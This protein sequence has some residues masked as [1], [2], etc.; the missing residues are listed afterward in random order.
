MNS[1]RSFSA[2]AVIVASIASNSALA[3]QVRAPEDTT[4]VAGNPAVVAKNDQPVVAIPQVLVTARKF[5][6][7]LQDAPVA[8]SAFTAANLENRGMDNLSE[9]GRATPSLTFTTGAVAS[10]TSS[11]TTVFMRGLGQSDY[12]M[13]VEPAVGIY[14]DGVYIARSVGSA[15]DFVDVESIEVLRGPQGTLF[16]RNTIGGVINVNSKRPEKEF[17]GDIKV[18]TGSFD[19]RVLQGSLNVPVSD[20][21]RTK[22]SL[23][24]NEREGNVR[25]IPTGIDLGNTNVVAG[26]FQAEIEPSADFRA[27]LSADMTKRRENPT[28]STAIAMSGT[29]FTPSGASLPATSNNP[30]TVFNRSLGGVCATKP[31][32]SSNCYGAA[33]LTNDP[34]LDNGTN[35][36][37]TH[38][39]TSGIS[40]VLEGRLGSATLKSI[41]GYRKLEAH[42]GRESDHTPLAFGQLHF[43]DNQDQLSQELQLNGSAFDNRFRYVLGGYGFKENSFEHFLN[44][45]GGTSTSDAAIHM[46]NENFAVFGEGTYDLLPRLHLTLGG[47][48]TDESKWFQ[49]DQVVIDAPP[50]NKALI[51]RLLVSDNSEQKVTFNQFTPRIILAADVVEGVMAYGTYSKGFKSGGFNGRYSNPVP[52]PIPFKP[53]FVTLYEA[54]LKFARADRKLR[55]N[56]AAFR[57]DYKDI[58]VNFKPDQTITVLGNAAAGQINGLEAELTWIPL[59]GLQFEGGLS[60]LDARYTEIG[61]GVPTGPGGI[62]LYTPFPQTPKWQANLSASYDFRLAN[63]SSVKPRI[64]VNYRDKASLDSVDSPIIRQPAYTLV[65]ANLT[66]VPAGGNWKLS[67]GVTN[68]TDK[69]YFTAG[70]FTAGGGI[71]DVIYGRAREWYLSAQWFF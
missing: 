13:F 20:T 59:A 12:T 36:D 25:Q 45:N 35:S 8:I 42:Y 6:E 69:R 48:W 44:V 10:G 57:M 64:D 53:E 65:N 38:L 1:N 54:G 55:L 46:K 47:R 21:V 70:N 31:D 37:P 29:G 17:G 60:Y 2:C 16:G 4:V 18:T 43:D 9:I 23:Y 51:G 26:R 41:T 3:Q 56:L 32:S 30:T 61:V 49:T 22:L 27:T 33:W 39:D 52:K 34:Y 66:F 71:A 7:K 19:R 68:L 28:P 24:S 62:N 58:Q 11:A 50:V 15:L 5:K 67:T 14:L 63:G 40:A